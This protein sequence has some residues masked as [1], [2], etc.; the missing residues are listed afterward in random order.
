MWCWKTLESLLDCKEIRQVDPKGKK[1][2]I[3]IGRTGAEAK[4]PVLWPPDAI[5]RLIGKDPGSGKD[6]RQKDKGVVE[7]GMFSI[8][9]SMEMNL[10]KLWEI[11]KKR[12]AWCV[13]AH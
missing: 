4:A 7:D 12:G 8:T 11:V 6:R 2:Y 1:P 9:D 10:S 3:F 5:C 13:V